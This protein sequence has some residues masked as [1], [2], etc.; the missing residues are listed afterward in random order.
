MKETETIRGT[1]PLHT[2]PSQPHI[3]PFTF[4][5]LE[6]VRVA[7]TTRRGG[8]SSGHC[9][10]GNLSYA[11]GDSPQHVQANRAALSTA[12]GFDT[13]VE[14]K[15][16]HGTRLIHT[17]A[18]LAETLEADGM[19]TATPGLGLCVKTA[20]C[21]PVLLAH[22][23]ARAVAALHIGWRGNRAAFPQ[24]AVQQFCEL[25]TLSPKDILAVRGPSLGPGKSE[26]IHFEREWG[27]D[28]HPYYHHERCSMD[29]WRLTR[30]QLLYAGLPAANIFS[31]DL[32][33]YSLPSL[34][35]SYRR[36][37]ACGRQAGLIWISRH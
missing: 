8:S 6:K 17:E 18:P 9:S 10:Q 11:V 25:Y 32:C 22:T 16:V 28:F 14:T 5:G 37:Q 34:F 26:F 4:P 36:D 7:F 29:L 23:S 1:L 12:C 27:A 3:I 35:F 19:A 24:Q 21:Q 13:L 15:Q 33:T 20:D 31:L 30:D 2:H